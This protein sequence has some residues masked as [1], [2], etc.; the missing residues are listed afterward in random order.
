VLDCECAASTFSHAYLFAVGYPSDPNDDD[1]DDEEEAEEQNGASTSMFKHDP[2]QP[3]NATSV[4]VK[5]E[6]TKNED[7][8][9]QF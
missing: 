3:H 8:H 9:T 2:N 7:I 1:S 5:L 6:V 4:S